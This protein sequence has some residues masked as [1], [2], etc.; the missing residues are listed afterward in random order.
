MDNPILM[1]PLVMEYVKKK[2]VNS[3]SYFGISVF[4]EI[5]EIRVLVPAET[6]VSGSFV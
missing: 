2:N 4:N 1:V 6:A 3:S 5:V